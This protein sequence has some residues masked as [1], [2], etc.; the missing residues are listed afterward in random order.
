MAWAYRGLGGPDCDPA[1]GT[2]GAG[3]CFYFNPFTSGYQFSQAAG[4]EGVASPGGDNTALNNPA[5]MQSWLTEFLGGK[6]ET[7][8]FVFD[9]VFNG[10]TGIDTGGGNV[11]WAA[12]VQYRR[13]DFKDS[14]LSN[15]NT[16]LEPCAFGLAAAGDTF[17]IPEV[18]LGGGNSIPEW[19]Y[20]C[21]GTGAFH[22]LAAGVPSEDDQDVYAGFAELAVPFSDTLNVQLAVRYEDYG[23][24][25]GD[26][27]D[28]KIAATWDVLET[29]RLRGSLTSS[30]RA[31]SLN[32]L[33]GVGTSLQFVAP[34][35]AFK[36]IDTF[37]HSN[38]SP[39]EAITPNLGIIY[40]PTDNIYMSLDWWNFDF[41]DP[42][43]L[44]NFGDVVGNCA[45]DTSDIQDLACGKVVFQDPADP[46]LAGIERVEVTYQNGP[47]IT[48]NGLDWFA[49]WDIPTDYGVFTLGTKGTWTNEFKID[50]WIWA[51]GFDAVGDLNRFE[52]VARPLPEVK[53][54]ASL[55]WEMGNHNVLLEGYY[56]DDYDDKSSGGA[57]WSID[58]QMTFDIS[59]NFRFNNG[60][61]RLFATIYNFTDEDPP[62]AHLDLNY[63]PYT[64]N[65]FGMMW[66]VG[67]THRFEGGPFQ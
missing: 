33:S 39:E 50:G 67:A 26:T 28:P 1:T 37:G 17:T 27:L 53:G 40:T 62:L 16:E 29:V 34:T 63:D 15:S 23:G 31:P 46:T 25:V 52:S 19:T 42:I 14:P 36:A 6:T 47:D 54:S 44:E 59:Y 22:F 35:G 32:Q 55:N 60:N 18:D 12:G 5:F 64:H 30:F 8:L 2:P 45:D 7:E 41:S 21:S 43:V 3:E 11:S 58:D 24:N 57:D 61:S 13:D 49:T 48:T 20:R 9:L 65:P 4:F 10:E 51:D 56:T 38:I 66:K